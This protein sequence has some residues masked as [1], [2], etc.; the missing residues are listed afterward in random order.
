MPLTREKA[1]AHERFGNRPHARPAGPRDSGKDQ[2]PRS[3]R[4]HRHPPP[5]RSAGA[6]PAPRKSKLSKIARCRSASWT[7]ISIATISPPWISSPWSAPP[8]SR[9][10]AGQ[11]HHPD[12]RRAVHRTHHPRRA[13]RAVRSR[14]PGAR[15]AAGADRPR[16]PRVAHRSRVRGPHGAD[17]RRRNHRSE[18][19][20]DRRHGKSAAGGKG[21]RGSRRERTKCLPDCWESKS[22]TAPRSKLFWRAPRTFSRCKA[23]PSR[24]WTRCAAR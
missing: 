18:V 22:W 16:P 23:S 8:I 10:G 9:F 6:A 2:R 12:G 4:L 15:A 3:A 1:A 13:R 11:G 5:R 17:Q 14:P 19:P 7:S 24:S 20:G 21:R